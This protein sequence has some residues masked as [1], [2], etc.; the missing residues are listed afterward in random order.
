M[1]WE[2]LKKTYL[3]RNLLCAALAIGMSLFGDPLVALV[4]IRERMP[5]WWGWRRKKKKKRP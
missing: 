4:G 1:E 5:W 3:A 2:E